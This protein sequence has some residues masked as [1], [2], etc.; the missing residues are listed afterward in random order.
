MTNS[1]KVPRSPPSPE[2]LP[3]G[4]KYGPVNGD[5]ER[6]TSRPH[7]PATDTAG[8]AKSPKPWALP[9]CRHDGG[10]PARLGVGATAVPDRRLSL[11]HPPVGNVPLTVRAP[12]T[13]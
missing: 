11:P 3:Q 8:G 6:A 4:G 13:A 7:K 5:Y 2:N 9:Y 1:P 10:S 12:M